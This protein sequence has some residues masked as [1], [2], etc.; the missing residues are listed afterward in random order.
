MV[1]VF[2]E[3][4]AKSKAASETPIAKFDR[5]GAIRCKGVDKTQDPTEILA[6]ETPEENAAREAASASSDQERNQKAEESKKNLKA[7]L[8]SLL[9]S[10]NATVA[11]LQSVEALL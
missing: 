10:F 1:D 9:S 4:D 5:R 11:Q 6:G 3:M 8:E 7:T 2:Q